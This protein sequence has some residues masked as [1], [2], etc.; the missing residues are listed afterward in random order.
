MDTAYRDHEAWAKMALL[1]VAKVENSLLTVQSKNMQKKS[2][3]WRKFPCNT[4]TKYVW[5]ESRYIRFQGD[6]G[7]LFFRRDT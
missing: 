6:A 7:F 3:N 2:G 1:N 5:K 4:R